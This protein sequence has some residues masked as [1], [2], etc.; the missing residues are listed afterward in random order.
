MSQLIKS[1]AH[2]QA[3]RCRYHGYIFTANGDG[4]RVMTKTQACQ[5]LALA[6]NQGAIQEDEAN[7]VHAQIMASEMPMEPDPII[8]RLGDIIEAFRAIHHDAD[9]DSTDRF[10]AEMLHDEHL[11][12]GETIH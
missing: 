12:G 3:C 11:G 5:V 8:E 2:F 7:V 6:M 4:C 10:L 9:L 1:A